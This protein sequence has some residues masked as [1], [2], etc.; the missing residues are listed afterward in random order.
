M[1]LFGEQ[2][3][4]QVFVVGLAAEARSIDPR[5]G[6]TQVVPLP[7]AGQHIR[8]FQGG[9]PKDAQVRTRALVYGEGNRTL[10]F[11]DLEGVRDRPDRALETLTLSDDVTSVIEIERPNALILTHAQGITLLDLEQRTATPIAADGALEGALFDAQTERLWVA[12]K[13]TQ[14]VGTLDLAS[15][16]TGEVRLDAEVQHLVPFFEAGKLAIVHR[17]KIGYVTVLDT[18]EPSRDRTRSVRGFFVAGILDQGD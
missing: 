9:S 5:S 18:D 12:T 1:A 11:V 16:E 2:A 15:G 14:W 10:M 13:N 6:K 8:L 7:S 17:S 4:P 3:D